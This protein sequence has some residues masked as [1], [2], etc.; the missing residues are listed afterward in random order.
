[1]DQQAE[2][3]QD[4]PVDQ[5]F[6][7]LDLTSALVIG[8]AV[9]YKDGYVGC[10]RGL[11]IN[12]EMQDLRGIV[13]RGEVTYGVSAGGC[14]RA[15]SCTASQVNVVERDEVTYGVSAGWRCADPT[16]SSS[17]MFTCT[18]RCVKFLNVRTRTC[19]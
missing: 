18:G 8:A 10:L 15:R 19:S 11:M 1:M 3:K 9:D 7:T 16:V 6:R 5:G 13:E 14:R 12:G 2:V 4:E 17:C